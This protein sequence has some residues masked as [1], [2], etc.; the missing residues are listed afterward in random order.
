[1]TRQGRWVDPAKPWHDT[2]VAY[3][4][5]CGRLIP[6]RSWVFEGGNGEIAACSPDC[7]DLFMDYVKPTYGAKG[8]DADFQG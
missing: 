8:A 4:G 3:C 2:N 5:V 7:E 6:R 1:L